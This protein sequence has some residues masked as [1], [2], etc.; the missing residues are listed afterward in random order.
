MIAKYIKA[1]LTTYNRISLPRIG[2]FYIFLRGS[3]LIDNRL[4]THPNYEIIFSNQE[5]RDSDIS[6][7]ITFIGEKKGISKKESSNYLDEFVQD[8][9]DSF[10]SSN[11]FTIEGM[12]SLINKNG[13]I[14]FLVDENFRFG[15]NFG[16]CDATGNP[17]LHE[18][19]RN[20]TLYRESVYYKFAWWMIILPMISG[21]TFLLY[22]MFN[23][24][25]IINKKIDTDI[26]LSKEFYDSSLFLNDQV[27][28]HD[29]V[30]SMDQMSIDSNQ[31]LVIRKKT[32]RYYLIV[33]SFNDL[34]KAKS[35]S[36]MITSEDVD[37]NVIFIVTSLDL[38]RISIVSFSSIEEAVAKRKSYLQRYPDIWIFKF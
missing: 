38:I 20:T 9:L 13:D 22:Y 4:F 12:G 27:K 23:G 1:F 7:L 32:D 18:N 2:T 16:L 11:I 37:A 19:N 28:I 35:H 5:I 14:S 21:I 29:S 30:V 17:I 31:I 34:E 15:D 26:P 36:T 6:L 8:I 25:E 33:A 10:S 24:S 3:K